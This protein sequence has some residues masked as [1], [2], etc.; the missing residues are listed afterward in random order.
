M[1]PR[2]TDLGHA[3]IQAHRA[4]LDLLQRRA[5]ILCDGHRDVTELTSLLGAGTPVLIRQLQQAGYLHREQATPVAG[6]SRP[7]PSQRRSLVA[8]R[9]YL[10][11]ILALQRNPAAAQLHRRLQT[12]RE[13]RETLHLLQLALVQLRAM[14]SPGYVQRV[15]E[16]LREVLPEVHLSTVLGDTALPA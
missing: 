13:E 10:L 15:R 14:T 1:Q 4:P 9:L 5:L 11:D 2:K 12:S 7:A 8:A 6:Q 16:H 3:A